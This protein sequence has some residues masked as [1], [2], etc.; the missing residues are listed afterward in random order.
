MKQGEGKSNLKIHSQEGVSRG[1]LKILLPVEELIPEFVSYDTITYD[2]EDVSSDI[3][4]MDIY[5]CIYVC[6]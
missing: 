5:M 4:R 6:T 2:E 1:L 3:F